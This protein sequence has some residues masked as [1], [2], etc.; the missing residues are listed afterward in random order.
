MK[1]LVLDTPGDE[2]SLT[3]RDVPVPAPEPHDVLVEVAAA[4][5]CHHDVAVI[6]GLLRRG[7]EPGIV[8][9]HEI[10][11]R[12]VDIGDSV[13][14]VEV[15]DSVVSTLSTFCGECQRCLHGMEYRCLNSQGVGHSIDGGFAQF[16]RLPE[17]SVVPIRS[18]TDLETAS[19]FACPM[20]VALRA[21]QD[22]AQVGPDNTVLVT[23]AGG[24]LGVHSMEIAAALGARVLAVTT[25]PAKAEKLE[26]MGRAEVIVHGDLDF[27]EIALALTEDQGVDVVIDTVG[28]ALFQS[29]LK[30]VTQFGMMVLLGEVAGGEA[31]VNPAEIIF[32]DATIV[33]SSGADRRHIVTVAEMVGS[34]AIRPVVSQRFALEDAGEAYRLMRARTT[35]GRVLLVPPTL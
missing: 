9:G 23:G 28:S 32:R 31:R 1:A 35:F 24:G 18:S 22:V 34:G 15:G 16:V 12:V 20:G 19:L 5:L 11:G 3:L 13:S 26:A 27:S 30:S 25:S 17:R 4:G 10:S 6:Q 7:V 33:G 14:S 21:L 29:S 2:P 8:L